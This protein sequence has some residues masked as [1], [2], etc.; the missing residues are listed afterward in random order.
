L[1]N[2][3]Y[4][5]GV[6]V[7][8]AFAAASR[9]AEGLELAPQARRA[10]AL[11]LERVLLARSVQVLFHLYAVAQHGDQGVVGNVLTEYH[12]DQQHERDL[13]EAKLRA[14][15]GQLGEMLAAEHDVRPAAGDHLLGAALEHSIARVGERVLGTLTRGDYD[16]GLT[17]MAGR[18][19]QGPSREDRADA[20]GRLETA[21]SAGGREAPAGGP[22]MGRRAR[23]RARREERLIEIG[24]GGNAWMTPWLRACALHGLD[25]SSSPARRALSRAATDP[26]PLVAETAA[27]VLAG[28][29][30]DLYPT[31][32]KVALL[33]KIELFA[34]IPHEI[35]ADLAPRLSQRFAA[36]DKRIISR[37]DTS[38]PTLYIVVSGRVRVHTAGR[39]LRHVGAQEYFG[40]LALL[41][42]APRAAD[43]TAVEPTHLFGLG[44][45]LFTAKL[46]QHPEIARAINRQLC[47][48]LR[49]MNAATGTDWMR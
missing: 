12:L 47:R 10:E 33:G 41:D 27:A 35:L 18:A 8:D 48:Q 24:L 3:L 37:G 38:D 20:V 36:A 39:V 30:A 29:P 49:T 31:I 46:A 22:A 7:D 14:D 43:V 42:D 11:R 26:H 6:G 15:L 34:T 13:A 28:L 2:A 40:E 21:L 5:F 17:E 45:Q 44:R 32:D 4:R 25:P 23:L 16:R 19:L 9:F 1:Q